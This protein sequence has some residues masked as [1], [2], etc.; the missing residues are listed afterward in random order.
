MVVSTKMIKFAIYLFSI[1]MLAYSVD[2]HG[3]TIKNALIAFLVWALCCASTQKICAQSST[4]LYYYQVNVLNAVGYNGAGTV[5]VSDTEDEGTLTSVVGAS[6]Y[7][8]GP[9]GRQFYYQPYIFATANS[10]SIFIGWSN[11]ADGTDI[12][13]GSNVSPYQLKYG[14]KGTS[15]DESNP[16]R[17]TYYAVFYSPTVLSYSTSVE[18]SFVLSGH[19][20]SKDIKITFEVKEATAL[21][22]FNVA[23]SGDEHFTL[24]GEP[25]WVAKNDN[26][27][28]G[29]SVTYMVRYTADS[30][31]GIFEST[32]NLSSR[33]GNSSLSCTF[34]AENP[35]VTIQSAV[36]DDVYATFRSDS[37]TQ[38]AV[39][40]T[41]V[42]DVSN[43]DDDS[44]FGTPFITA[45]T[46][47]TKWSVVS[48]SYFNGKL[49][50]NYL[51]NGNKQ[52]GTH[53]ATL[54]ITASVPAGGA[55]KSITLTVHNEKEP[56]DDA[57][58]TAEDGT[59]IYRGKWTTALARANANPNCTLALLRNVEVT[60]KQTTKQTFTL[61]F[62]GRTISGNIN[63]PVINHNAA[64]KVLTLTDSKSGGGLRN[65]GNYNA[66]IYA[67]YLNK[68][69]V[70]VNGGVFHAENNAV[71]NS[72]TQTK[73]GV[74]G[75]SQAAGTTMTIN[76]GTIEAIGGRAAYGLYNSS[77]AANTSVMNVTGGTIY[78]EAPYTA[79][80][81]A[82]YGQI[83]ISGGNITA[84][85]NTGIVDSKYAA[86]A[87]TNLDNANARGV[88]VMASANTDPAL[89][90]YGTLTMT[91]GTVNAISERQ[92]NKTLKN[93]GICVSHSSVAMP[94]GQ[95]AVDGSDVQKVC[96]KASI[97][98]VEVNVVSGTY[99]AIGIGVLAS[100]NACD[101]TFN[102]VA[103]KNCVV[104]VT[105]SAHAYGILADAAV[106]STHG[107]CT[108]GTVELTDVTASAITS[109][110]S[111]AFALYVN[112][113]A[114]TVYT[115]NDSY[116][117]GEYAVAAKM[118]VNSGTYTAQT[119]TKYANAVATAVRA[120][121]LYSPEVSSVTG[122]LLGGNAEAYPELTIHNGLFKS[123]SG[124]SYAKGL[125]SGGHTIVLGG[126]FEATATTTNAVGL[127]AQS[128]T[129][130]ATGATAVAV[131]N[132]VVSTTNQEGSAYGVQIDAVVPYN[133]EAPTG[134][135][136]A[137]T[138]QLNDLTVTA[139]TITGSNARAVSITTVSKQYT[140]SQLHT[141]SVNNAWSKTTYQAYS[142]ICPLNEWRVAAADCVINGGSFTATAETA[143]AYGI[144]LTNTAISGDGLQTA[145]GSLT[146]RNARFYVQAKNESTA[147]G[148][149][150]GGQSSISNCS[151][152]A[153]AGTTSAIGIYSADRLTSI[154]NTSVYATSQQTSYGIYAAASVGN[155][156]IP[157]IA[158]LQLADGNMFRAHSTEQG[159]AYC[160]YLGGATKT[161]ADT[162]YA[163]AA[164][165]VVNGGEY[166]A[167]SDN[168]TAY[169]VSITKRQTLNS[170]FAIPECVINGGKFMG[171]T[172][173]FGTN[174][175]VG[176]TVLNGGYYAHET[177]LSTYTASDKLIYP[178]HQA[179]PVYA[180]GYSY[181][182]SADTP[183]GEVCRIYEGNTLRGSFNSLEEALQYVNANVNKYLVIVLTTHYTLPAGDYVLPEKARLL[184]P[185]KEGDDRGAISLIGT[186]V[187][188]NYNNGTYIKPYMYRRLTL[189]AGANLTVQGHIEV[190]AA[191]YPARGGRPLS[192]CVQ[193]AYGQLHLERGARIDLE[194]TAILYA[195]G[196]VTGEGV[197]NAK[198]NSF[199]YE[200]F[201]MGYWRGG[202]PSYAMRRNEYKAFFVTDY[203]FQNIECPIRYRAGANSVGYSSVYAASGIHTIDDVRLVG[204]QEAMFVMDVSDERDDTWIMRD[205]D[206]DNDRITWTLNSGVRIENM[207]IIMSNIPLVGTIDMDSK[208]YNLPVTSNFTIV[209]NEGRF[210]MT[211]D[212][213]FMPGTQLIINKEATA[214]VSEGKKIY[215]YDS[216]DWE[217]TGSYYYWPALYSPSWGSNNPR[218]AQYPQ[219]QPLPDAEVF[220]HGTFEVNGELFTTGNGIGSANI[221]STNA[222][223]GMIV[224][225]ADA[226]GEGT[227]GQCVSV[228]PSYVSTP[229]TA[230]QLRN[231][232]GTYT[233]TAGARA[234]NAYVYIRNRW[235]QQSVD[236]CFTTLTD[237][238]GTHHFA[239]PSN[240]VEVLP[241]I[242]D[243]AF[244]NA[245]NP[246]QFYIFTEQQTTHPSC[247]WW[248][249][250]YKGILDGQVCYMANNRSFDNYGTYYYF[251]TEAG[252]WMPVMVMVTWKNYDGTILQ[253][254]DNSLT[255]DPVPYNT[256][257]RYFGQNPVRPNTTTYQYA[258]V[259]WTIEGDDSGTVYDKFES[260]PIVTKNTTFIAVIEANR[261][262]FTISFKR[263]DGT[264]IEDL[265]LHKGEIPVCSFNP[266]TMPP[267]A[268]KIYTFT[269]WEGYAPGEQLPA[270]SRAMTYY[271]LFSSAT[272]TYAVT[273]YDNDAQTVLANPSIPY[274]SNAYYPAVEPYKESNNAYSFDFY[275]W[276]GSDGTLYLKGQPLPQVTGETYYVAQYVQVPHRYRITFV[277]DNGEPDDSKNWN[278]GDLPAYSNGIPVKQSTAEWSYSFS[279]WTPDIE[280]VTADAQ[281]TAVYIA[282]K[283][284]YT[285]RFVA[286]DGI[287]DIVEP[288][289]IEYGGMPSI[290]LPPEKNAPAG[291]MYV[292]SGWNPEIK[293]VSEDMVYQATYQLTTYFF[294]NYIDIID[295]NDNI[296]TICMNG[297]VGRGSAYQKNQ[298]TL[299]INGLGD[300][301]TY[302]NLD[303]E[304]LFSVDL[305]DLDLIPDDDIIMGVTDYTSELESYRKYRVPYVINSTSTASYDLADA[306]ATSIVLV[307]QDTLFI[308]T[309]ISLSAIY[310]YPSA[311]LVIDE[312]VVLSLEKLVIRTRPFTPP[313]TLDAH[314]TLDVQQMFYT[315]ISTDNSKAYQFGLPY[316]VDLRHVTTSNDCL[317]KRLEAVGLRAFGSFFGMLYYNTLKQDINGTQSP[318]WQHLDTGAD[319]EMQGGKG[320]QIISSSDRYYEFYFPVNHTVA[321]DYINLNYDAN[322]SDNANSLTW[323]YI[324]SP[325]TS[326]FVIDTADISPEER[327][328]ITELVYDSARQQE[329]FRQYMPEIIRP[330][331]PFY[332]QAS[333]VG[334]L[335]L[336]DGQLLFV[337][338]GQTMH[339]PYYMPD[340]KT[341]TQWI[342]ILSTD[343]DG[344]V[345][346]THIY[347]HPSKFTTDYQWG[348][349]LAKFRYSDS[350]LSLFT[351][352]PYGNLAFA[353]IPDN[354]ALKG[355]P[356]TVGSVV[357]GENIISLKQNN[358]LSRLQ[359]LI[360]FDQGQ[361]Q[362]VDLLTSD[363]AFY[364]E[365]GTIANRFYLYP[366]LRSAG[367]A[368]EVSTVSDNGVVISVSQHTIDIRLSDNSS[369]IYGS[370]RCYDIIGK[371]IY[372][373]PSPASAPSSTS[374]TSLISTPSSMANTIP[375]S[376]VS[377]SVPASGIY[378]VQVG[379]TIQKVIVP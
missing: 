285:I 331:M 157:L 9:I 275:A 206:Q 121:S 166:I 26:G 193:G 105:C 239:R 241:N 58:V 367:V 68:G 145:S 117:A 280:L 31:H 364:A 262:Q 63:G 264:P 195:W 82:G 233:Q 153:R 71:Y 260:L 334:K 170:T 175:E 370:I 358:Y 194:A 75:I 353:A 20:V 90:Y 101:N 85:V 108:F 335:T 107:G 61:D 303:S 127:Y 377:I 210:E 114:A 318:G 35:P 158:R 321:K 192:G 98:N 277:T 287:T 242:T 148:I 344:H 119:K 110:A 207:H 140:A 96:A 294:G 243:Q 356:L 361:G 124:T 6:Q 45:L 336:Q 62:N 271:A 184:I 371:L 298:W 357:A 232:D 212:I 37:D 257:P 88:L 253:Y 256:S 201:Q 376:P 304:G 325:L 340:Y 91:G 44:D 173:E 174:G 320:Y 301:I 19:S 78:A 308:D 129:L 375:I 43:V 38:G 220:I 247:L 11:T 178:V 379:E 52:E 27:H 143:K 10:K 40:G 259:G 120:R 17:H 93:Y 69:E 313:P 244:H 161:V 57:Q 217:T 167:E 130:T 146:V 345:D 235:T 164:E 279:H 360:L 150:V 251:D 292:F 76:G 329:M 2:T 314:G 366:V 3:L 365:V 165:A 359:S 281:Y 204:T 89:S 128:G 363:Y 185:Y 92:R 41:A 100:F 225:N 106:S 268:D 176:H 49:T 123:L 180:Q 272:R 288:Q 80:G 338:S 343:A 42:F 183:K 213:L 154:D 187:V 21:S 137:A 254:A 168:S 181:T 351:S 32:L 312:G 252:F 59:L 14:Y 211:N 234:G 126:Q 102:T 16:E 131:A 291:K 348:Y 205:Y 33:F 330:T 265:L 22:D 30:R 289:I 316:D 290:P 248:E 77:S 300:E 188:H 36:A 305:T 309:D 25:L 245:S 238:N 286:D 284:Q 70:I 218:V 79:Y 249:A 64:D 163:V 197:I 297:Y 86:T 34:T 229:I 60:A 141:D 302:D 39:S 236:G 263:K 147:F 322:V 72:D 190:S 323:N 46:V 227:L 200:D 355:I 56:D 368:T 354:E 81:V 278:Y 333:S 346:Q 347:L 115:E 149:R 152:S 327:I 134:F 231:G 295:W 230:A 54:K 156:G 7:R 189:A 104:N 94:A 136:H 299:T 282:T 306:S 223:A 228:E 138:A 326:D 83:N 349:D 66:R 97:E 296:M 67:F 47:G 155:A 237:N 15:Y 339:A 215:F 293:P 214:V 373:N 202:A 109:K 317:N 12:I 319:F 283:R 219:D 8:N 324:V 133:L 198:R 255:I 209:L 48:Q 53:T 84:K 74:S 378:T 116:H 199:I 352:L 332:Y 113:A 18:P 270:V 169:A 132:G 328:K 160:I 261:W 311:H 267:S 151:I 369:N 4:I 51:F 182:I 226:T 171:T 73:V 362:S 24:V 65:V 87:T 159:K 246:S 307:R 112:A 276:K 274:G 23:L 125:S 118:T 191:Q 224:Y 221:H 95:R 142:A 250:E 216:S 315:H 55:A 208:D 122:R 1:C 266:P 13:E 28:G 139:V 222:D 103:I 350:N 240:V 29:Y 342:N 5:H 179:E 269:N 374:I 177:N 162:D 203:C 50:I 273:F 186:N 111:N 144:Y 258:W 135:A 99:N 196:F 372:F 310:V 337:P 172:A 341:Q